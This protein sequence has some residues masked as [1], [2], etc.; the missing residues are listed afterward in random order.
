MKNIISIKGSEPGA[1]IASAAIVDHL[2]DHPAILQT[3]IWQH[4][5]HAPNYP[6][7]RSF[8]EYWS[9]N[10]DGKLHSV[11]VASTPARRRRGFRHA[12]YHGTLH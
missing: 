12:K 7:L 2:P 3:F 4:H 5:D 9:R 8:L 6:R 11:N 10:L 1:C